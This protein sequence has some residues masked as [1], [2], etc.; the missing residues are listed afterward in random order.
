MEGESDRAL[1]KAWREGDTDAGEELFARH[2][3]AMYRFFRNKAPARC[4]ELVQRVF[5]AI[6]EKREALDE[7]DSFRAY[8]FGVARFELL[9][10]FREC[11]RDERQVDFNESS[12]FEL[13]PTPSEFFGR[14]QELRLLQQALRRIPVELQITIELY[15]WEQLSME[16]IGR[17]SA[18]PAGTVKSR[19]HRGRKLLLE[20]VQRLCDR[21]ELVG[22]TREGFVDWMKEIRALSLRSAP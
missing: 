4:D 7:V 13:D 8:L 14:R 2:F 18:I 21:P 19:L 17:V 22:S 5:R 10:F 20:Q 15:Y 16:E 3:D 9:R 12:V 11:R 1:V 6:V